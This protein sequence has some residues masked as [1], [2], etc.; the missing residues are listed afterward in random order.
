MHI[1]LPTHY[2]HNS[3]LNNQILILT[4]SRSSLPLD[5]IELNLLPSDPHCHL[6][7]DYSVII[8]HLVISVF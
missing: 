1:P 7:L 6:Q 2:S 3:S 5:I 4:R 8:C